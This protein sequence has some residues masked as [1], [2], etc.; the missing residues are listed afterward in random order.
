MP[1]NID[2]PPSN[3]AQGPIVDDY[4][5][6]PFHLLATEGAVHM[7]KDHVWHMAEVACLVGA[8]DKWLVYAKASYAVE[9]SGRNAALPDRF[10]IDDW[11]NG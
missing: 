11:R 3:S 6:A 2:P 7:E 1:V 9:V 4:R 5:N 8:G 10:S